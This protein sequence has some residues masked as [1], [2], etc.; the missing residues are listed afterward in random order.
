M[1]IQ[2]LKELKADNLFSWKAM[3]V[4]PPHVD[5]SLTPS[6]LALGPVLNEMASW[7]LKNR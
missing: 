3:A 6:V 7:G 2:H 1:L 5:Y 4:V